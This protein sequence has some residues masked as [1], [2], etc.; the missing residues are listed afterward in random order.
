MARETAK[1]LHSY[2]P[3]VKVLD[4]VCG[5]VVS[6]VD[7]T[8]QNTAAVVILMTWSLLS[9][10]YHYKGGGGGPGRGE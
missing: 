5:L 1:L 3:R 10:H 9:T 2:N 8:D 4:V 7:L 6:T